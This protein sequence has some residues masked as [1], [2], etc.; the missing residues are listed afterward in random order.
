MGGSLALCWSDNNG[1]EH[2]RLLSWSQGVLTPGPAVEVE[3]DDGAAQ[4][5]SHQRPALLPPLP[6]A[7]ND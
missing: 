7:V 3:P 1:N 6:L 2:Q 4:Q 5:S